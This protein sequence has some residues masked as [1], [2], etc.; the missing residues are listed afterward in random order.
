MMCTTVFDNFGQSNIH[1][2]PT[3]TQTTNWLSHPELKFY[4]HF[5]SFIFDLW[6]LMFPEA[7]AGLT[8]LLRDI[9][10]TVQQVN[11]KRRMCHEMW[12]KIFQQFWPSAIR[13]KPN[14]A[15]AHF[16]LYVLLF[17][18]AHLKLNSPHFTEK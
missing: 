3:H 4:S 11:S 13:D 9:S 17:M 7:A 5:H 18:E 2:N 8:E 15:C 1:P 16:C 6:H 12:G 10:R 14:Q